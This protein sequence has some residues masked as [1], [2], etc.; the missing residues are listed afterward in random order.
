MITRSQYHALGLALCACV[1]LQSARAASTITQTFDFA[2]EITSWTATPNET[3]YFYF[4][5]SYQANVNP[6]NTTLGVLESVTLRWTYAASFEG[7]A[8]SD[9]TGGS[10][11]LTFGG[12]VKIG[13]SEYAGNGTGFGAGVAP[14]AALSATAQPF[15]IDREFAAAEAGATYDP[16]IWTT[17]TG[18]TPW[19]AEFAPGGYSQFSYD[20]VAS[21][22]FTSNLG[23]E[24]IYTYSAVP[25]P[26]G[27]LGSIALLS[28]G[29]F[30]RRRRPA[31]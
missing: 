19:S 13:A 2:E 29:M 8:S 15:S 25:E 24:V 1:T 5:A 28:G 4:P 6:F 27:V 16:A 10:V 3:Q 7:F 23:L 30:F 26:A 14:D 22:T 31:A 12:G 21:G 20:D 9:L 17:V 18:S 11:G